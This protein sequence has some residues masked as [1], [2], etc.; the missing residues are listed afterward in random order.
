MTAAPPVRG[1][2]AGHAA[3]G[4]RWSA[5][6]LARALEAAHPPTAEQA[7]VIEAPLAP[8]VVVAGAGSGKTETMA[9]RVVWLVANGFVEPDEVLG[10]T[11]TR[12][13]AAEL[14]ER[15]SARLARL[16]ATG[17]WQPRSEA[18]A[19][20]LGG[21]PTIL[22]YHAY[23]GLLVSEHGPRLGRES[24]SRVLSEAA[25][26][27]VAHEVVA[28]YDGPMDDVVKAPRTVTA[29]V[30]DLAG[31]L[32]EHLRGVAETDATLTEV[33]DA[34][35]AVPRG[36]GGSVRAYPAE[37]KAVV[38]ALRERRAVLPVVSRFLEAKR[39]RDALDFADQ[40]SLA[41]EIATRFPDVGR[42]ERQR[43]R[44]V[45]LDEFQDTSEAQLTFL[46]RLFAAGEEPAGVTAVGDPH[47]SI[48]GWRGAS[49]TTLDRFRDGFGAGRPTTLLHLSTSWRNDRAVL[50]VADVVA[51]PL[52]AAA[53][54]P[55]RRLE[56]RPDAGPGRVRVA[57]LHTIEDEAEHVAHWLVRERRRPDVRT[58]AVLCRKRS[59]FEP[60]IA[61]LEA[62][63]LPVEVVG[64]GGLLLTPEVADLV[65][66]LWV[67]QDPTRGDHLARLLTGTTCRLGAADLDG[68]AAWARQ[69]QRVHRPASLDLAPDSAERPSLVEALDVL[70]PAGWLGEDGER[71]GAVARERL[72]GLAGT[73]RRLRSLTGL[74]L[75][76]LAAEAERALGLDIEVIARPGYTPAAARAHLDAFADVA[77][78][79]S[80][81]ADRPTLGG[82]L[83]WV[84]A[85]VAEERGLDLGWLETS[86]EAVQVMTVHAAKGLEWDAVAVPALLESTFP[87]HSGATS[88]PE[89][90]QWRHGRPTDK[91]WL[92]GVAGLPYVLRGD[93][94]ALP[95]FRWT[96]LTSWQ[97]LRDELE[98]FSRACAEHGL[99]EE[100]RL[101]YV[102]VT[103]ARRALLVTAHV[104][105]TPSTPRVTSRFLEEVRAAA[106]SGVVEDVWVDLP[107]VDGPPDN[108]R[109][110]EPVTVTWPVDRPVEAAVARAADLVRSALR[111][112]SPDPSSTVLPERR[113]MD[114]REPA[115][116]RRDPSASGVEQA[117][118]DEEVDLLLAERDARRR[119][120][121][122]VVEMPTHLST[123]DLV[124]LAEDPGRFTETLR[125]PMP[126]R[127]A[128]A[129]R[130]G[131]AFHAWV[132]RHYARA[133]IVDVLELP[134]SAD[135]EAAPDAD[136]P[137]LQRHFL[138]SEW[139]ARVPVEVETPLETVVAGTA[140][141]GRVDAVFADE[142]GWV[143]VDW[144]TGPPPR[145]DAA[146]VRAVQ[147]AAY[148]LAW[149][150]LRGVPVS[151]VR[152]AFFY[153]RTGETV[154]PELVGEEELAALVASVPPA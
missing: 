66:L 49:A 104:W 9:A 15:V 105:G 95:T 61:A 110:T 72:E 126:Q 77:A 44:A 103:R 67:V 13:A 5:V 3:D 129:A 138:A 85:A 147:L 108:P 21:D 27:Q 68:L 31:E 86:P 51:A 79:F 125:R 118:W 139:A 98:R 47:Q 65:A 17:L 121:V 75:A 116:A 145:G 113:G 94:A 58:A 8:L 80:A 109:T 96:R 149:A 64:L 93:A 115:R 4:R 25:A 134:G 76:D 24:D 34:L 128:V 23:A 144:K 117:D 6:G 101:A 123:S 2:P 89:G 29:G 73:V 32:A 154:W 28:S 83:D 124:A 100:R 53:R 50:D 153:A 57:R 36:E 119:R 37:A 12:K 132:E 131:T 35:A 150:R 56:P 11:F 140:L 152:A 45:L 112:A 151:S 107:A 122:E 70:P 33:I 20:V 102:A 111:P 7:A 42:A 60:V 82:F 97:E 71:L 63:G 88:R 141:R 135:E 146:R 54:V 69:R 114:P 38:A 90:G 39:R 41:A 74:P 127:P 137:V 10:L 18:G 106:P 148:R 133:A 48:Y 22:T 130:R 142:P 26:W 19:D 91:G 136:L 16:R 55:V 43:F 92:G 143:V 46:Q 78:R 40:M 87:A 81:T 14:S 99:T 30:L 59:S 120:T 52:T 62:A 1:R 84:E